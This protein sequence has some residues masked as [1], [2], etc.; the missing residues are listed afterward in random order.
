MTQ[1]TLHNGWQAAAECALA[2]PRCKQQLHAC[3]YVTVLLEDE[4]GAQTLVNIQGLA[5]KWLHAGYHGQVAAK[6]ATTAPGLRQVCATPATA[7]CLQTHLPLRFPLSDICSIFT[8]CRQ[9]DRPNV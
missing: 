6:Q 9:H 7:G 5:D 2:Y 4:S 1:V 8:S 3:I